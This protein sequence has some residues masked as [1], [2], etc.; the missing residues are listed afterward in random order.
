MK[1]YYFPEAA[2]SDAIF[3]SDLPVCIDG[4]E[5]VRLASEWDM[6]VNDLLDQLHEASPAEIDEFGT[7]DGECT[8]RDICRAAGLTQA[9][10]AD[11]FGIPLRTV[12]DWCTSRR[13]CAPYIRRMMVEI[14]LSKN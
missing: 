3:G 14:L 12:E 13:S 5:V 7:Y 6:A 4:A 11:R 10:L 1:T 9:A 8:V 2:Y